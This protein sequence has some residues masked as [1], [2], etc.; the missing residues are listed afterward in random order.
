MSSTGPKEIRA[1]NPEEI[2]KLPGVYLFKDS[3]EQVIYVG[4]AKSLRDRVRSY[5]HRSQEDWKVRDL[6]KEHESI[7]YI[8]THS[9]TEALLLEAQL[10]QDLQPRYNTLLRGGN[11]FLYLLFTKTDLKLVRSKK[12]KGRYFGP[13]LH[14]KDARGA[15][16]YLS[17]TFKLSPCNKDIPQGCLEYHLDICPGSC[18]GEGSD[19][20]REIRL[21]LA[22]DALSGNH[23]QFLER[24]KNEIGAL[25]RAREFEKAQRLAEYLKN[26]DTIFTTIKTRY[27]EHRY[28]QEIFRATALSEKSATTAHKGLDELKELL[29]LKHLPESIDCF[30]ISHFQGTYIVGSCVR[31]TKGIPDKDKFRRFKIKSLRSHDDYKA[32]KEIVARRYDDEGAFDLPDVIMVDG[33]KGQLSAVQGI[34]ENVPLISLAKREERL[35]TPF[36]EDG[37]VL[38]LHS[39][40]GKLLIALRDYTHHS[41]ILYHKLLRKKGL[42]E[43]L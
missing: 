38:N 15:Y 13:F 37:L 24:L 34:I 28:A 32:L 11:P 39:E 20:E 4:K 3:N 12:E 43:N 17:R 40:L 29:H 23:A 10:I 26:L 21:A 27:S 18:R 5:F 16:E 1:F 6:I 19:A 9:E 33:G 41:A 22:H 42:K 31:F 2:P 25:S 8:V 35:Y 36:H 30:D 7:S 14:K